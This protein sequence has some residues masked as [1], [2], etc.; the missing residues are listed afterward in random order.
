M[1]S[2]SKSAQARFLLTIDNKRR[3]KTCHHLPG[4]SEVFAKFQRT[5]STIAAYNTFV[6]IIKMG[7]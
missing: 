5:V 2:R 6:A 7:H 3:I 4:M 1:S